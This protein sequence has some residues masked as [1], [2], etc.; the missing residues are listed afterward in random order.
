LVT[1][2]LKK[3]QG[4]A[5]DAA[6]TWLYV[7]DE[8]AS[9]V[10]RFN[11]LFVDGKMLVDGRQIFAARNV[12]SRWVAADGVG[13]IFFTDETTNLIWTV[14][15][16]VLA[17]EESKPEV[18]YAGSDIECKGEGLNS[19]GFVPRECQVIP[20]VSAPG[21]IAADNF[22]VFWTNKADGFTMGSVV[23]GS[24]NPPETNIGSSVMRISI[25]SAKVYGVCPTAKYIYY[26][27]DRTMV[28]AVGKDGGTAAVVTDKLQSP[29]GCV[30]DG[31]GTIY[32]ADRGT[33]AIYSLPA[34]PRK[35]R[36][37][38]VLKSADVDDAFG[39]ALVTEPIFLSGT[40][41][42][43]T[44]RSSFLWLLGG[45]MSLGWWVQL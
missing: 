23:K 11:L 27:E 35:L 18:L 37:M 34:N 10:F 39:L 28:Y 33:N 30:W 25:T 16:D 31:D 17:R 5:V 13:N 14:P 15:Q 24:E 9:A 40:K 7:A 41:R 8:E 32:V 21:G 1:H 36:S 45:L 44:S 29:R 42:T 3:P 43:A 19:D 6:R 38:R 20:G 2:G 4:I 26:T 12:E 22:N